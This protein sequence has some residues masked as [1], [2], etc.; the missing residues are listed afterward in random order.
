MIR[1]DLH[2]HS[3]YSFDSQESVDR[4]VDLAKNANLDYIAISDHNMT[5]G[6]IKLKE[7][8]I[9]SISA[10]E[11]D[12]YI[13]DT[14]IH[15]LGY[16]IDLNDSRY[17]KLWSNYENELK[18][19]AFTRVKLIEERYNIKLNIDKIKNLTHRNYPFTN[20]EITKVLLE[21][22]TNEELAL[23]QT[24]IYSDNPIANYYWQNMNVGHWGYVAIDLIDYQA[25]I[26]L[27]HDTGGVCI[28]AHPF[29]TIKQD[30]AKINKLINSGVDGFEVYCNYHNKKISSFY[31][32][33]CQTH[34]LL[35]TAG[36]DYH[37]INKP[38]IKLGQ[39]TYD[40]DA[41]IWLNPL[42]KKLNI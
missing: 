38:N 22:H 15:L 24:G 1:A 16:G 25:V 18:R 6:A 11:I 21:D 39:T 26:D 12:C 30:D 36:S 32:D 40:G 5:L 31:L 2:I 10:I 27:I 4:I 41:A 33:I 17:Q 29:Q 35:Y 37:G 3:D 20:V 28:V 42:L 34:N 9:K 23:Y 13:D 19:I 14:V 8:D 7:Y